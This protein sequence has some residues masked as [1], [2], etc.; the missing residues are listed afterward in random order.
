MKYI[1]WKASARSGTL[2]TKEPASPAVQQPV[3][4]FDEFTVGQLEFKI[5]CLTYII[6]SFIRKNIPVG[7]KIAGYYHKPAVS[8]GHKLRMLKDLALYGKNESIH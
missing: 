2:K 6:M 4:D 8:R 1:N 5:S 3:F 7:L